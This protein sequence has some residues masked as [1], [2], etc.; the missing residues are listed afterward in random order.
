M[1]MKIH[2]SKK[3]L[4]SLGVV[5]IIFIIA[6]VAFVVSPFAKN[7]IPAKFNQARSNASLLSAD[8]VS[9]LKTTSDGIKSLQK[10]TQKKNFRGLDAVLKGLQN[11]R[12]AREKAVSLA[13]ELENM[14]LSIPDISPSEA[15]QTAVVAISSEAAL[16][17]KMISYNEGLANLLSLLQ[18]KYTKGTVGIAQINNVIDELNSNAEQINKFNDQFVKLMNTFDSYYKD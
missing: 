1:N 8:I 9:K 6:F 16:I 2:A 4:Y 12:L 5:G 13:K 15:R 14:A 10:D 11:S 18:K 3:L 7:K 17:N